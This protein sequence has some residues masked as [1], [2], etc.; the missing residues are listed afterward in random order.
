MLEGGIPF[1]KIWGI[2]LRLHYSWFFIFVLITWALVASYFS[3]SNPDWSLGTR[4]AAGIITSL[5]FFGSV[6]FHELMH[7]RV[8]LYQGMGVHSIVLFALGGVSQIT[9]EPKRAG[10][11]FRMALAG[12]LSSLILGG[13]FWGV[14]LGLRDSNQFSAQFVAAIA[15]W[16]GL[17][18]LGLGVFNLIPGFPLDGGRVL[19]SILWRTTGDIRKSTAIASGV[20]RGFGYLFIFAGIWL[21]FAG[22]F[23]NGLWLAFIGWFLINAASGSYQQLILQDMLRKHSAGEIMTRECATVSPNTTVERLVNEN[24]LSS[25]RRCFPVLSDGQVSGLVTVDNVRAVP[26]ENWSSTSVN[27]VMIPLDRLKSVKPGD[28]LAKVMQIL[29]END[30]NQ[31]PVVQDHTIV[32]MIGRDNLINFINLQRELR[33]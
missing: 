21:F 17:I 4:I 30:I 2:S 1:G 8:A 9:S 29:A 3:V 7:S 15:F 16:L 10:D 22:F 13:I 23:F 26:H 19:R 18:N 5:L 20:G 25:G 33:G 11:E 24:I 28:D 6:L 31:A 12:P 27:E 32:G 14:W